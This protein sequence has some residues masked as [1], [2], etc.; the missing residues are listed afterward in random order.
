MPFDLLK[1]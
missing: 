1:I